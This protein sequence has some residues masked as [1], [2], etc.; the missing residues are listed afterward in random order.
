MSFLNLRIGGRLYGGFSI[1]LLFCAGLAAFGVSQLGSIREQVDILS[2]QS[3]NTI[4]VGEITTE[5]QAIRRG[6]LRY[7]FD[8]D[9][10]SLADADKRLAR[11][12]ELLD[13][14]VATTKSEERKA[15][16]RE[17]A[18]DIAD[19]KTK[20]AELGETVKQMQA[21]RKDALRRGRQDGGRRPEVRGHRKRTALRTTPTSWKSKVLLVRVANWRMLATRDAK[22]LATFKDERRQGAGS[23]R[24]AREG[25][26]CR[27]S[28]KPSCRRSSP[29]S[30]NMPR[31]ST[32]PDPISS[33]ATS[34][35]TT[36]SR[37][38]S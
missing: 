33:A 36:A 1:L 7:T 11:V 35:I 10:A 28:W 12:T 6:I 34:S 26:T 5:L 37:R 25:S 23:D 4:R 8:Q 22:G 31:R 21:G 38:R 20:R 9:E 14:A 16:Y 17:A 2:L 27:P 15:N 30:P 32:R 29:M 13:Q 24:A 3:R 18:K 19:L